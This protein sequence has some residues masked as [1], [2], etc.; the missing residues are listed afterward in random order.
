MLNAFASLNARKNASIMYKSLLPEWSQGE[1]RLY[2]MR[3][4]DKSVY[5]RIRINSN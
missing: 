1:L 4:I 5:V 2:D 3:N